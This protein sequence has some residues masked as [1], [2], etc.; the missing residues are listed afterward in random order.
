MAALSGVSPGAFLD[1]NAADAAFD[2]EP[3][4]KAAKVLN[5]MMTSMATDPAITDRS[6]QERFWEVISLLMKLR[7]VNSSPELSTVNHYGAR[8]TSVLSR[9]GFATTD[10]IQHGFA[11]QRVGALVTKLFTDGL[12][13]FLQDFIRKK[14][15]EMEKACFHL[16]EILVLCNQKERDVALGHGSVGGLYRDFMLNR[17]AIRALGRDYRFENERGVCV[18]PAS[19]NQ[20]ASPPQQPAAPRREAGTFRLPASRVQEDNDALR[21]LGGGADV[22]VTAADQQRAT[23]WNI[24]FD[25]GNYHR[26]EDLSCKDFCEKFGLAFPVPDGS[27]ARRRGQLYRRHV[28]QVRAAKRR[29][30]KEQKEQ[31]EQSQTGGRSSGLASGSAARTTGGDN[32]QRGPVSVLG[33]GQAN[34]YPVPTQD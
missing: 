32:P 24:C 26:R 4:I 13:Q 23:H 22:L 11:D 15:I 17:K 10:E 3:R 34:G 19:V 1:R 16:H 25:C 14:C 21:A 29:I 20:T 2:M 27:P 9:Y 28:M 8:F 31:K 12:F 7:Q 18:A 30:Q 5:A 33:G 6:V